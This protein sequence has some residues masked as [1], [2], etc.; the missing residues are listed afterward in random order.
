MRVNGI[1]P[2][3]DRQRTPPLSPVQDDVGEFERH[4][5]HIP[6]DRSYWEMQKLSEELVEYSRDNA[7]I[8]HDVFSTMEQRE[9]CD[10][11]LSI[12]H[13]QLCLNLYENPQVNC[14]MRFDTTGSDST[15]ASKLQA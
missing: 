14:P 10:G 5:E 2:Y 12:F 11:I 4:P 1:Q 15:S 8:I 3:G 7:P 13:A 6:R 9:D